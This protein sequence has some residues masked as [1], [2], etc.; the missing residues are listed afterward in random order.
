MER[1][2]EFKTARFTVALEIAHDDSYR[3]D[4]EDADGSTQF[5]LDTG[6]LVA[7]DSRVV[8]E[9]DG[10]EIGAD[11]L[12]GSVYRAGDESAFWTDHRD[13]DPMNRNCSI[14][15]AARGENCVICHYFPDMVRVAIAEARKTLATRPALPYMRKGA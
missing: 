14:M 8:V 3:Y 15:R 7:F 10:Q 1:V 9:L 12:G 2:W 6:E 5:D 13:P 11:H 4:G